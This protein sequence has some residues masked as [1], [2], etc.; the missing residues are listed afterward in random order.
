MHVTELNLTHISELGV[1][2]P[3]PFVNFPQSDL[4][5]L[6]AIAFCFDHYVNDIKKCV[7]EGLTEDIRKCRNRIDRKNRQDALKTWLRKATVTSFNFQRNTDHMD[8]LFLAYHGYNPITIEASLPPVNNPRLSSYQLAQAIYD[9]ALTSHRLRAP[10]FRGGS[11]QHVLRPTLSLLF[12]RY[13]HPFGE[14][15]SYWLI[16][17]IQR[18][19]EL[20]S[21]KAVPWNPTESGSRQRLATWNNWA[22]VNLPSV[23]LPDRRTQPSSL[24]LEAEVN[25]AISR[26]CQK[27]LLE[28]PTIPW[29]IDKVML[30]DLPMLLE[31]GRLPQW[32][33]PVNIP[34]SYD[35]DHDQ[36]AYVY[37]T[38][39][40]AKETFDIDRPTHYIALALGIV[41]AK[42]CPYVMHDE[43]EVKRLF[44]SQTTETA[45]RTAASKMSGWVKSN[46]LSTRDAGKIACA[47]ITT[48]M[49]VT[50][51]SSPLLTNCLE[52]NS[53]GGLGKEWSDKHSVGKK[54]PL[55]L[56]FRSNILY[57]RG[58]MIRPVY[59]SHLW[60]KTEADYM[61]MADRIKKT[62]SHDNLYAVGDLV[63]DLLGEA[64]ASK[65]ASMKML[66]IRTH[67]GDSKLD[68]DED[69][70]E[71]RPKKRLRRLEKEDWT[72]NLP[73]F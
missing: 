15:F 51:E 47:F 46:K 3:G 29:S 7:G 1:D 16:L 66:K 41:I 45:A 67:S 61:K 25:E 27:H 65:L 53:K 54:I 72:E 31:R 4:H 32:I 19:I 60:K 12:E 63:T 28:D 64:A 26:V 55:F 59:N 37:R 69:E 18:V 49:A 21:F 35:G 73:D 13:S 43:R 50:D 14:K 39:Q 9:G 30:E 38:Y 48:A 42:L 5:A 34:K 71:E 20:F 52:R 57:G 24:H 6:H 10:F 23:I 44:D 68:E 8:H 33:P 11:F 2:E 36:N 58:A 40:W 17:Q 22:L 70:Y 62:L 56:L